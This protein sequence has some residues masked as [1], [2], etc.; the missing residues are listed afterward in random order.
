MNTTAL[1]PDVRI[2]QGD[3]LEPLT[4]E[5]KGR[6]DLVVS[7]PPYVHDEAEIGREVWSE[8]RRAVFAG[9]CG[10]EVLRRLEAEALRFLKSAG[11]LAL[12]VGTGSQAANVRSRLEERF[13]DTGVRFDQN[14]RPRV[15]W[16]KR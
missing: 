5:L 3:L 11:S 14:D 1:A 6:C 4:D 8:P 2:I 9:R 15:V 13:R 10:D 16:G 12:E 7:N